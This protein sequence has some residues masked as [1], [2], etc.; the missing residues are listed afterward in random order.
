MNSPTKNSG[1]LFDLGI[2]TGRGQ[3]FGLVG[4]GCYAAQA[5]C[6][7][8]IRDSEAYKQCNLSW[9]DFCDRHVGVARRQADQIINQLEEF[10]ETY[11]R[12]AEIL[13][14]SPQTYRQLNGAGVIKND[15]LE[16]DGE[17]VPLTPEN[18]PRIKAAVTALRRD[19]ELARKR[20][21]KPVYPSLSYLNYTFLGYYDMLEEILEHRSNKEQFAELGQE[22][23]FSIRKLEGL[24][25]RI[26]R[27]QA[28]NR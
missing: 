5:R 4:N 9:A 16:I 26:E 8:E 21:V 12:L 23:I 20:P 27:I 10:G 22:I 25:D 14:I 19:L 24:R 3:A 18:A 13:K 2:Q 17:L 1:I 28:P 15:A 11:F 7:K 6:L